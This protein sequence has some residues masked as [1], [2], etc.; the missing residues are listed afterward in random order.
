M[1]H[2]AMDRE[3]R[4]FVPAGPPFQYWLAHPLKPPEPT[5]R[6]LDIQDPYWTELAVYW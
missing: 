2:L 1:L 4:R 6:Q 5:A 3:G